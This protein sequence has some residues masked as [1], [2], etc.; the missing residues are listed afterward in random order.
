[1]TAGLSHACATRNDGTLWCWGTNGD[2]ELGTGPAASPGRPQQVTTPAATGWAS[3]T[4]GED[5]TCAVRSDS[6]LWCWGYNGD[7]ELGIGST[8]S[9]SRPQQVTSPAAAGWARAAPGLGSS[10]TC[11]LRTDSTL[12]CW[13]GNDYGQLGIGGT[14]SQFLPRQVTA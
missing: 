2:G 13:G 4:A 3:V 5:A 8:I 14:T 1:M 6:T 12:W 10:H 7:G 11:A 9:H